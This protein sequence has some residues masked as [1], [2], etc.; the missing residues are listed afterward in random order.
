M[1]FER[2]TYAV[3]VID[4]HI[5]TWKGQKIFVVVVC[6][7]FLVELMTLSTCGDFILLIL[8]R[9]F[10]GFPINLPTAIGLEDL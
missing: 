9:V 6:D 4:G 7:L 10:Y 5:K 2:I 1:T 8:Q 3:K